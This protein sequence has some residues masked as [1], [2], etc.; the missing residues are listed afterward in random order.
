MQSERIGSRVSLAKNRVPIVDLGWS[1]SRVIGKTRKLIQ[2]RRLGKSGGMSSQPQTGLFCRAATHDLKLFSDVLIDACPG[3]SLACPGNTIRTQRIR[4]Q[5]G[6]RHSLIGYSRRQTHHLQ[7]C[8]FSTLK[9][10]PPNSQR[11]DFS[12]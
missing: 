1:L 11:F 4:N 12:T 5:V 3:S 7:G 6:S 9:R 8:W 10:Y 2:K